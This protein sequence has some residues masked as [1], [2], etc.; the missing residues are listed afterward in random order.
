MLSQSGIPG[1][2]RLVSPLLPAAQ[3]E[4]QRQGEGDEEGGEQDRTELRALIPAAGSEACAWWREL[5]GQGF[6][7]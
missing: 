5:H 2:V 3:R 6:D 7:A 1:P 4:P